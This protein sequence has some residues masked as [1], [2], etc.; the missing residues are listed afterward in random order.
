MSKFVLIVYH[1]DVVAMN[2]CILRLPSLLTTYVTVTV[3]DKDK[4]GPASELRAVGRAVLDTANF[5]EDF[6][7]YHMIEK[8]NAMHLYHSVPKALTVCSDLDGQFYLNNE[9]LRSINTISGL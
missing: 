8:L 6:I 3:Q 7:S 2:F 4:T 9:I 1:T 5:V